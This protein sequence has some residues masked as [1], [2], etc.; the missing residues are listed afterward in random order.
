MFGR[1][2]TFGRPAGIAGD[3]RRGIGVVPVLD[4]DLRRE[5]RAAILTNPL[6][7]DA[8]PRRQRLP[9]VVD[10]REL[11]HEHLSAAHL[12]NPE[13]AVLGERLDNPVKMGVGEILRVRRPSR[14]HDDAPCHPKHHGQTDRAGH[15]R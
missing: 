10:L 8:H 9:L 4:F 7:L 3:G 14:L 11:T 12:P 5:D 1:L 15:Q 6:Y 13:D 2:G